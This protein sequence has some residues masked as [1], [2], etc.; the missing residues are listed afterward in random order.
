[1]VFVVGSVYSACFSYWQVSQ[2]AGMILAPSCV[3]ISI[4]SF[5]VFSIW[6]LNDRQPLYPVKK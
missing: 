3:W 1:M 2:R 4:A 6:T 5:L